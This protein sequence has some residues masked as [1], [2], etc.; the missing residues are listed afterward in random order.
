MYRGGQPRVAQRGID[1]GK[2]GRQV[3]GGGVHVSGTYKPKDG[4]TAWASE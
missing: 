2:R 1:R 4:V 3:R